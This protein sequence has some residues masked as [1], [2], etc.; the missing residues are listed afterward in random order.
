MGRVI[1]IAKVRV[2]LTVADSKYWYDELSQALA[3]A[4]TEVSLQ[5]RKSKTFVG[6]GART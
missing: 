1:G 2:S 4:V 3:V 5:Y 6:D